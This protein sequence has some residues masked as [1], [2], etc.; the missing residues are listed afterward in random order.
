MGARRLRSAVVWAK[1]GSTLAGLG[2]ARLQALWPVRYPHRGK[3]GPGRLW[4][5]WSAVV[6]RDGQRVDR[7]GV[8]GP[9]LSG[10]SGLTPRAAD[11]AT[12]RA[13][14]GGISA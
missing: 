14:V 2:R 10:G 3:Q 1:L 7:P 13:N 9:E 12:P 6:C 4:C 11:A 5:R 8:P